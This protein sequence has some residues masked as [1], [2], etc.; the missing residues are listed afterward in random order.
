MFWVRNGS[1]DKIVLGPIVSISDAITP[2]TTLALSTADEAE[3][4]KHNASAVTDISGRTFAAITNADGYYNYTPAAGDFDTNGRCTILI[5]DDSLILPYRI[6]FMIL[7]TQVYDSFVADSDKIQVDVAQWNNTNVAT[8]DTAGY[9]KTTIKDGTGTGELDLT[10]GKVDVNDKTDFQLAA[11]HVISIV[12]DVWD[13]LIHSLGSHTTANSAAVFMQVLAEAIAGRT[14]NAN[15]NA[16]LGVADAASSD[17]EGNIRGSDND[18]LKALSDEVAA[19]NNVSVA[20]LLGGTIDELTADPGASP[21]L[22]GAVALLYM[23]L[24]NKRDLTSGTYEI[25]KNDDTVLLTASVSNNGTT[26]TKAK[27]A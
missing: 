21:T 11:A 20:D 27:F 15:L 8:P 17:L 3:L 9:P 6:D 12:D 14:N 7:P 1:T 23:W 24:R 18:D 22:K 4:I 19:L 26:A 10:S 13:E 16:L 25:H 2:V 5:N